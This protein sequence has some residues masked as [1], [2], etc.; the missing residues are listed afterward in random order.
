MIVPSFWAEAR[1]SRRHEGRELTVRRFGWSETSEAE[2]QAS[3]ELR[4]QAAWDR[5]AAGEKLLRR[6]PKIPYNGADGLPIREEVLSRQGNTV[7]TRNAYGAQCLNT[8]DVLFADIDFKQGLSGRLVLAVTAGLMLLALFFGFRLHSFGYGLVLLLMSLLMA[9][10]VAELMDLSVTMISGGAE[11]AARRRI[12]RFLARQPDW[13]L[14][15]YRTPAGLRL[16]AMHRLFD[17]AEAAVAECFKALGADPIY[18]QMCLKQRCFRARVSPKPWRIGIGAHIRPR[19][20]V[21]PVDPAR[22]AERQRWIED[23]ERSASGHAACRY[24]ETLGSGTVH[25]AAQS[26]QR[27]HDELCRAQQD[28]PI[29]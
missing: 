27:L 20:G 12:G 2:A 15:L 10:K 11:Q 25:P 7:I 26:V 13:Q 14:R 24:L 5:I 29:A 16:L 23:Y 22:R 3:A 1:V 21:W 9:S 28:L 6:E 18:V 4:A 19:P 8:P 17:P